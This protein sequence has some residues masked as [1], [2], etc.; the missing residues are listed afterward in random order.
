MH[1]AA[2]RATGLGDEWD[3]ESDDFDV[4]PED[5]LEPVEPDSRFLRRN[6]EETTVTWLGHATFLLQLN[7]VNILTDPHLGP[8]ASALPLLGPQR[9]FE[10]PMD[11]YEL[12]S[13]H[14]IVISHDHYDHLDRRTLRRLVKQKGG[15]ASLL[16]TQGGQAA[17]SRVSVLSLHRAGLVG[18]GATGR[19]QSALCTGPSLQW[20]HAMAAQSHPVVGLG[21]RERDVPLLL[22]R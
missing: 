13:I 18:V 8:R 15:A 3:V 16:R 22:C 6:R 9:A 4:P 5:L 7:G 2:P 19:H 12:P 21:D 10:P 14:A 20:P 17:H 1:D 11:H